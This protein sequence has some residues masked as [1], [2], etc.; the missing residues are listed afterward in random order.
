MPQALLM[1]QYFNS[2]VTNFPTCWIITMVK[3]NL[4]FD[5]LGHRSLSQ[6]RCGAFCDVERGRNHLAGG[7]VHTDKM[8]ETG[9]ILQVSEIN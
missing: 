3:L 5:E 1:Y 7:P 6:L 9:E 2:Q 4:A 8:D